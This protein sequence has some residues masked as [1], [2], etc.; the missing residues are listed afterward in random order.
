MN[1]F[2]L[3]VFAPFATAAA[4]PLAAQERSLFDESLV[5]HL[6]GLS[7]PGFEAKPEI[8]HDKL[9]LYFASDQAGGAGD[10]DL[11]FAQRATPSAPFGPATN[12]AAL[13]SAFRDHTPTTNADGTVMIFSSDRPGGDGTD[14]AW[15]ATRTGPG[16]PWGAPVRV[17]G[18]NSVDRDMGYSMTPDG[19]VLYFTSNR[20]GGSG[21]FDLYRTSRADASAPWAAPQPVAELNTPFDDKFPSVTEDELTLYFASN[22]PGSELNPSG[23]LTSLD[24][25]VAMRPTT[26]SPW[27]VV[28]NVFELNT[29]YNEYLMSVADDGSELFF[30][31]NRPGTL[32]FFDLYRSP[33]IPG[34]ARYGAATDGT[35]GAPRLRP[36]GGAP[37]IGNAAWTYEITNVSSTAFGLIAHAGAP[38]TTPF[39]VAITPAVP[40]ALF[41]TAFALN[42]PPE[43]PRLVPTPIPNDPGIVGGTV[44]TQVGMFGDPFGAGVLPGPVPFAASPG[45]KQTLLAP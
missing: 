16:G 39:L 11:W 44:Y 36:L 43:V 15:I 18:I 6:S 5:E 38:A 32:G 33:A 31:S 29:T 26:S 19:L 13:N 14:D 3:A 28:E 41:Q 1:R 34:V 12:E 4:L 27:T 24:I 22:R 10:L 20:A 40:V 42:P 23:F 7:S 37:V 21:G 45:L 17:P 30:V 25:W 9:T 35:A 2:R 8:S